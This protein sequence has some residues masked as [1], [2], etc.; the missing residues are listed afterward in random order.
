MIHWLEHH[1]FACFFK[2]HFG[3]ECPGC[4]MQRALLSLLKGDLSESIAYHAALIPFLV[5]IVLLMIQLFLKRENG[6]KYVMWA[7]IM[8]SAITLIQFVVRQI[9]FFN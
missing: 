2:S 7:F 5:T 4:G 9:L 1:L 8:T 6:G 3:I